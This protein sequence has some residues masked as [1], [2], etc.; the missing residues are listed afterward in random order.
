M[1]GNPRVSMSEFGQRPCISALW[2]FRNHIKERALEVYVGS[3]GDDKASLGMKCEENSFLKPIT[4]SRQR[5][6][7]VRRESFET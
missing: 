2:L 6:G 7:I 4:Y 5:Q 1:A 3:Q